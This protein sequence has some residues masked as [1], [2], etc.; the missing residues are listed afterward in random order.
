VCQRRSRSELARAERRDTL[1][2]HIDRPDE[3]QRVLDG[4]FED[5]MERSG[6]RRIGGEVAPHRVQRYPRQG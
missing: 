3:L 5:G 6:Y 1:P 4:E 2:D